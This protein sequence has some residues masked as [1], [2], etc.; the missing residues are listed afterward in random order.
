MAPKD[1][2][3]RKPNVKP[4]EGDQGEQV[5]EAAAAVGFDPG[6]PSRI[7]APP[8]EDQSGTPAIPG[9]ENA[10]VDYEAMSVEALEDEVAR[11]EAAGRELDVEGSGADG[12]VLKA[13]LIEALEEDDES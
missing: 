12:N 4:I 11:R 13:D 7:S 6:A 2:D 8:P 5:E 3:H 9:E 1:E 10:E